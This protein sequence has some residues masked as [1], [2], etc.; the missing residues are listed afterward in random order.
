MH[1]SLCDQ[2]RLDFALLTVCGTRGDW[3]LHCLLCVCY[4]ARLDFALLAV[5]VTRRDWILHC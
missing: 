2:V 5:C 1:C 3:I 4:Q